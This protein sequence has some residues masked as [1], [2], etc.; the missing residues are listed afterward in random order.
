M[1]ILNKTNYRTEDIRRI[2][3]ECVKR[4]GMPFNGYIEVFNRKINARVLGN[5]NKYRRRI[6]LF[7]KP[8][9]QD[10]KQLANTIHHELM[11]LKPDLGSNKAHKDM[12]GGR[13]IS[14]VYGVENW[15]DK[16]DLRLKE[17]KIKPKRDLQM[18]RY[19]KVKKHIDTK[20]KQVKRLN[21]QL[22]KW[23]QKLKY[24]EKAL[25]AAGKLK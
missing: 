5:C 6:Q 24:Y 23:K 7:L 17:I 10:K 2:F 20:T 22:Y 18:E 15:I 9:E 1:K 16:Y 25:V 19:D 3:K 12:L 11:H 13:T 14:N 8:I 21:N 4:E